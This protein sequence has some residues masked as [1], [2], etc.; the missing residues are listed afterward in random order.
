VASVIMVITLVQGANRYVATTS[1]AVGSPTPPATGNLHTT[2]VFGKS[3]FGVPHVGAKMEATL[4]PATATD[5]D[6]LKQRRKAGIKTYFKTVILNTN[7]YRVI[8]S[9]SAFN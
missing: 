6:P 4:T 9:M 3:A 7:F 8:Q 2:Y 5:S 1:G